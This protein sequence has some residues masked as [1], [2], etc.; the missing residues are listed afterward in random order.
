MAE[1]PRRQKFAS[2]PAAPFILR[3]VERLVKERLV[4]AAVLLAAAV[5]LIPEMLS[6]PKREQTSQSAAAV[7]DAPTKTYTID[8]SRPAQQ[9][10]SQQ[11]IETTAAPPSEALATEPVAASPA[12]QATPESSV[13][14]SDRP[15]E[16]PAESAREIAPTKAAPSQ[17][18]Q[19]RRPP[20]AEP[21]TA[22]EREQQSPPVAKA[23]PVA[24]VRSVPT[25]KGWAVQ[26]GSFSN[27]ET[28]EHLAQAVRTHGHKTFVMPVKTGG[29]TLY[30][31][32]VGPVAERAQADA[33]QRELKSDYSGATVVPHP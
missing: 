13:Q 25:L 26:L 11:N 9:P 28:A 33:L 27:E 20:P 5:I 24:T 23:A 8:L 32:R 6:G 10:Q 17:Q 14:Q 2:S 18:A 3:G 31:V 4:G 16:S 1:A 30:R 12:S 21:T 7:E 19:N 15:R 29:M 22:P